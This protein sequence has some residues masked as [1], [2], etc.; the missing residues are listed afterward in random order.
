[1]Y[2]RLRQ[3]RLLEGLAER[4]IQALIESAEAVELAA[5]DCLCR[6]G[7]PA[8]HVFY[9]VEG[10]AGVYKHDKE[11]GI[12]HK[13]ET[14]ESGSVIGEMAFLSEDQTRKATVRAEESCR[15]LMFQPGH[16]PQHPDLDQ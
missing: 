5:G 4:Q 12:E 13:I 9:V 1:M 7:E 2:E 10:S 8:E 14:L 15:V 6:E 16:W 11:E 3:H